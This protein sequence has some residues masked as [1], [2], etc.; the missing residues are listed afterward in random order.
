MGKHIGKVGS[1]WGSN[2]L[3]RKIDGNKGGNSEVWSAES[4]GQKTAVKILRRTEPER[5]RRFLNEIE[6]HSRFTDDGVLPLLESDPDTEHPWFSMPI[7]VN[8]SD[9]LA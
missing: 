6:F 3:K 8:V 7:A 4:A 1:T 9:A 2:A 5:R